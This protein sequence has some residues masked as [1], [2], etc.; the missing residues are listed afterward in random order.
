MHRKGAWKKSR[1]LILQT[2]YSENMNTDSWRM[3][4]WKRGLDTISWGI[5]G[6][7]PALPHP[8]AGPGWGALFLFPEGPRGSFCLP[9][10]SPVTAN[11]PEAE[12]ERI[13]H[14]NV[15]ISFESKREGASKERVYGEMDFAQ[16]KER[17][18]KKK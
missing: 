2:K 10:R 8:A 16:Y 17:L 15:S 4:S 1:C 12:M 11:P 3:A 13:C 9:L 7:S 5:R 18:K 6:W 14:S